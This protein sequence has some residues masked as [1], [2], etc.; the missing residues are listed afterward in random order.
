MSVSRVGPWHGRSRWP[1]SLEWSQAWRWTH[2]SP[3]VFS[4]ETPAAISAVRSRVSRVQP[5]P[6]RSWAITSSRVDSS[7]GHRSAS[8]RACRWI[9]AQ[10]AVELVVA[11]NFVEIFLAKEG[12]D[13]LVGV[14]YLEKIQMATPAAAYGAMLAGVDYVLVGAGIPAE[15]PGLLDALAAGQA[16]KVSVDVVG[17]GANRYTVG[18]RPE[19]VSGAGPRAA[20]AEVPCHRGLARSGVVSRS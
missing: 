15:L 16:G 1:A 4:S 5:C 7:P 2:C 20:Q 19:L 8:C 18:V 17:A 10:H 12:H 6:K 11:A 9:R 3:A 13:G 14:N